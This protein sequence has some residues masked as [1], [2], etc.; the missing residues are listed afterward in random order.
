MVPWSVSCAVDDRAW[1]GRSAGVEPTG[2]APE[3]WLGG[4][5]SA[6]FGD[7]VL[8]FDDPLGADQ[9]HALAHQRGEGGD[10]AELDTAVA[11]LP[12]D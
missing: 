12:A 11:P 8:E 9:G 7:L 10:V 2:P 5:L 1:C 4:Q 6:E 3:C